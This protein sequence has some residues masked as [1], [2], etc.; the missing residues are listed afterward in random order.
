MSS[1]SRRSSV[2]LLLAG[3]LVFSLSTW[4]YW[5]GQYGP[6]LLDDRSSILVLED[7]REN[8]ELIADA[9]FGDRSGILG[10]WVSMST[11][12]F[13]KLYFGDSLAISKKVNIFLH[14]F[15]G[16]LLILLLRALLRVICNDRDA[17]WLALALGACWLVAPLFVSTVLYVVQRMAMLSTTFMLLACLSYAGWRRRLGEGRFASLPLF[18]AGFFTVFGL[19]AKENTIVVVPVIFLLEALWYQWRD[20]QGRSIAWLRRLTLSGILLGALGLLATLLLRYDNLAQAFR[21]RP[22]SLEERLLTQT[23][24][25]WDYLGQLVWPDLARLGIYHDDYVISTGLQSPP[26]TLYA[27]VAWLAVLAVSL[28]LLRWPWGRRLAIGPAWYLLAHAVESSVLPLEL[29]FE[30]RNYFP[31][32]GLYLAVGGMLAILV[33]R[34]PQVRAPAVAWLFVYAFWLALQTSSQVVVWSQRE[35]I[36][37]N[38]LNGHPYSARANTDMAVLMAEVGDLE[39]ARHYSQVAYEHSPAKTQSQGDFELRNLALACMSGRSVSDDEI[40]RLGRVNPQRPIS[41]VTTLLTFVRLHQDDACP[42]FPW[43]FAANH[44]A[45]L[46]LESDSVATAAPNVHSTLASLENSLQRY[47]KAYQ[48]ML[49]FREVL[50]DNTR[51]QLMQLHFTTALGKVGEAKDLIKQLQDK[52]ARGELTVGEQQNLALYLPRP[53][54]E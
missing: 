7:V 33:R 27:I 51:G 29:Y 36:I 48:Y 2:L 31:V 14:L 20:G 50:P 15:N 21:Y 46:Y 10:R 41:S 1:H 47:D 23:R 16:L 12:V 6:E 19:F 53:E 38:H 4:L 40:A 8:P 54:K 25:L 34:M 43:L 52:Q 3:T 5:P 44:L 22:F 39:R 18:F 26:T 45:G 28:L 37:F 11:F 49:R 9:I 17:T 24:A 13:E 42:G 32:M 30:H 35:L